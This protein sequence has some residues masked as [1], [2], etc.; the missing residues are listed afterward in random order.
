MFNTVRPD[1]LRRD[2]RLWDAKARRLNTDIPAVASTDLGL[3]P[4][5]AG[6][7][8][9]SLG[10]VNARGVYDCACCLV[11]YIPK[12]KNFHFDQVP[13]RTKSPT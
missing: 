5:T 4:G 2:L 10:A 3:C 7:P 11:D 1:T 6:V 9:N 8:I 13:R 12:G